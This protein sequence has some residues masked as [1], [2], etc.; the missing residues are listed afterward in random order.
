MTNISQKVNPIACKIC[1][2]EVVDSSVGPLI[3][4]CLCA[5]TMKH[6]HLKCLQKWLQSRLHVKN[7][8]NATSYHWKPF[9]CELCKHPYPGR[10]YLSVEINNFS[11]PAQLEIDKKKCDLVEIPKPETPYI[12]LEL[13][14]KDSNQPRGAHLISMESKS[15]V[16]MVKQLLLTSRSD[17]K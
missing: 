8:G 13:L 16:R 17:C 4:P 14:G 5:G 11:P 10:K 7:N 15:S 2:S 3:S 9:E 6:V 12:L 1:L